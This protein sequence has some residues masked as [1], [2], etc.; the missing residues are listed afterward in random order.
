MSRVVDRSIEIDEAWNSGNRE[1]A[2]S[3]LHKMACEME[4]RDF[5]R[6]E[7]LRRDI[8]RAGRN[9]KRSSRENRRSSRWPKHSL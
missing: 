8:L 3:L 1:L 5:A 2:R 9:R 4:Q 7:K 6:A